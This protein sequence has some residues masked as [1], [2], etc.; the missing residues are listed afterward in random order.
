MHKER[1]S[2]GTSGKYGDRR[3]VPQF[4]DE[5]KLANSRLSLAFYASAAHP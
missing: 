4:F 5:W 2:K 1:T 3:D